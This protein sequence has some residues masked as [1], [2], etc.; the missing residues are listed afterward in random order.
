[1]T[2]VSSIPLSVKV[3][4][5]IWSISGNQTSA[6]HKPVDRQRRERPLSTTVLAIGVTVMV[7]PALLQLSRGYNGTLIGSHR[8]LSP[9][10]VSLSLGD[11]V[12]ARAADTGSR[13]TP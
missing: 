8:P 3:Y 10:F 7:L 6:L 12:A 13:R 9:L 4:Q 5:V 1:M 2:L 11:R